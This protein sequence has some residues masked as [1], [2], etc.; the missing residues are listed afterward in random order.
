MVVK[1]YGSRRVDSSVRL[2][3]RAGEKK[4][5]FAD[6]IADRKLLPVRV[7]KSV[8]VEERIA[9]SVRQIAP[10]I[11]RKI[12][13]QSAG[14]DARLDVHDCRDLSAILGRKSSREKRRTFDHFRIDDF[15]QPA[16]DAER[17]RSAI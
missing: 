7:E 3:S 16:K 13:V 9:P 4:S 12:G 8:W 6:V 15:I 17:N 11:G 10:A 5:E 1:D 14:R 2:L